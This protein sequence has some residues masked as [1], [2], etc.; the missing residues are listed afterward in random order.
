MPQFS[1]K[2]INEAKKRVWEMQNRASHFVDE[3]TKPRERNRTGNASSVPPVFEEKSAER[4]HNSA[5]EKKSDKKSED[6]SL[7]IILALILILSSEGADN[8]LILALLYL[9]L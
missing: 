1:E 6:Q 2:D 3:S 9:L 4:N 5:N 8:T 7:A